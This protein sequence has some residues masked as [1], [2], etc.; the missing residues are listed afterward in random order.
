MSSSIMLVRSTKCFLISLLQVSDVKTELSQIGFDIES[1]QQ[2]LTGLV[3][4]YY[5]LLVPTN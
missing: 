2:M 3:S 1:L 5:Y 4:Y